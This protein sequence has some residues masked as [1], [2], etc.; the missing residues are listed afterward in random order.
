VRPD[1]WMVVLGTRSLGHLLQ[2]GE[3]CRPT[4]RNQ[5]ERLHGLQT[6]PGDKCP[7][8]SFGPQVAGPTGLIS[9]NTRY[10]SW[11]GGLC[12]ISGTEPG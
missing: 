2:S 1:P 11:S 10:L 7:F 12:G 4:V 9:P 3:V 8:S 5:A 6:T